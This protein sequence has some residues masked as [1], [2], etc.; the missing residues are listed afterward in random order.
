LF[1]ACFS[2]VAA[3][4]PVMLKQDLSQTGWLVCQIDINM[5][6]VP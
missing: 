4:I 3:V 2:A 6:K 1:F 5:C